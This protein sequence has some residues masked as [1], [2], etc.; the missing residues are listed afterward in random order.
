MPRTERRSL[1]SD[2]YSSIILTVEFQ[3]SEQEVPFRKTEYQ[4][5]S[6]STKFLLTFLKVTFYYKNQTMYLQMKKKVTN[7]EY[8]VNYKKISYKCVYVNKVPNSFGIYLFFN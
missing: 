3:L 8:Y 1:H 2:A 5:C 4:M 6:L 7:S